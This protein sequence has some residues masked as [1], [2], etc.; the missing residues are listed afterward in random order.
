MMEM[1]GNGRRM[2]V[3]SDGWDEQAR[4]NS[5]KPS[6][7]GIEKNAK[8]FK[9]VRNALFDLDTISTVLN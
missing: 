1:V 9:A 7:M 5:R 2:Q 8:Q 3:R 4:P 6:L